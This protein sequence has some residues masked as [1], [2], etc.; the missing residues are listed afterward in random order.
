[1]IDMMTINAAVQSGNVL[2][3]VI[4][5]SKQLIEN[6]ELV[7]AV[8]EMNTKL[9]GAQ[10]EILTVYEK[11]ATLQEEKATLTERVRELEQ[12]IVALE[13]W[14]REAERYALTEIASGVFAHCLK[15]GMERG[16]PPHKLCTR[17]YNNQKKGVLQS[18]NSDGSM[19]QTTLSCPQ[20][21]ERIT[22]RHPY[23]SRGGVFPVRRERDKW[24]DY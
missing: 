10:R 21:G 5:A 6:N 17:C 1:M 16:D 12:K 7:T 23:E 15:Q 11:Q 2:W 4:T 8:S 20:C 9:I 14:E 22:I 13:N 3:K 24:S 18:D 19:T